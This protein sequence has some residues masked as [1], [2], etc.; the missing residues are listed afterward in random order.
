MA[1]PDRAARDYPIDSAAHDL[2]ALACHGFEPRPINLE[3]AAPIGFQ[4]P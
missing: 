4:R 1:E 3:L 2:V